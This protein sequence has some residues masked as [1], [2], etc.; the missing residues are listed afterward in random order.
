MRFGWQM[1]STVGEAI[2]F[3][4]HT[5]TGS[6]VIDLEDVMARARGD[7]PLEELPT[8]ASLQLGCRSGVDHLA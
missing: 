8:S 5:S 6:F 2:E 3:T 4:V 1:F 7:I